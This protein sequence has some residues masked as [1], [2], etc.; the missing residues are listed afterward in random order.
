MYLSG[1]E[2]EYISAQKLAEAAND[3]YYSDPTS[4]KDNS[5]TK[6]TSNYITSTPST[7]SCFLFIHVCDGFTIITAT[8]AVIGAWPRLLSMC[9]LSSPHVSETL[10]YGVSL[11]LSSSSLIIW[12]I[13][14]APIMGL[15][16]SLLSLLLSL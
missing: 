11:L 5:K 10:C 4:N 8:R 13:L 3:A 12:S 6:L 7:C 9:G 1:G 14:S 16:P 15:D 2:K